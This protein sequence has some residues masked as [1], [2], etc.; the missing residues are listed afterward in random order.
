MLLLS[1]EGQLLFHTKSGVWENIEKNATIEIVEEE[2]FNAE[3]RVRG[4]DGN[5]LLKHYILEINPRAEFDHQGHAFLWHINCNDPAIPNSTMV[6]VFRDEIEFTTWTNLFVHKATEATKQDCFEKSFP[7]LD[8]QRYAEQVAGLH[9]AYYDSPEEEPMMDF[10]SDSSCSDVEYDPVNTPKKSATPDRNRAI[11]SA[12]QYDRVFVPRGNKLGV[13]RHGRDELEYVGS[14]Q[15]TDKSGD[16][17]SP[18]KA[19][20]HR[21]DRHALLLNDDAVDR[22]YSLDLEAGRVV[23]EYKAGGDRPIRGMSNIT[24][25]GQKTDSE[26]ILGVNNNSVFTLD[27][28]MGGSDQY[29]NGNTYKTKG[30][31]LQGVTSTGAG[32]IAIGSKTG[33]I[34]LLNDVSKRAKSLFPGIGHA[35]THLDTTEDGRFVLATTKTYL[36][37]VDTTAPDGEY[38]SG[39]EKSMSK[40]PKVVTALSIRTNFVLLE[41]TKATHHSQ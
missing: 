21:A 14:V 25:Y 19:I 33:D 16:V 17:F 31:A 30:I 3:M 38:K 1:A 8:D 35:I 7:N 24:K 20:L 12:I 15:V 22:M 39:Y 29:A 13:F 9:S 27:G 40:K 11:A 4:H 5:D 37:L 10:D 41:C 26:L 6:F 34:R 2:K 23:S 28:R 36:L 32:H 18:S